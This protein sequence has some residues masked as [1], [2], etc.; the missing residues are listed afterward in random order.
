MKYVVT[1]GAGFIGSHLVKQLI[2]ENHHVAVIDTLI[3]GKLEN[4]IPYHSEVEFYN[5]DITDVKAL[6]PVLSKADGIFHQAALT[7]VQESF[8]KPQLYHTVNVEGTENIFMLAKKFKI[9][10]V[11]ASSSSVYG[12][13]QKIPITE[14]SIRRPV[15]PYGQT[16]LE[17]EY[18]AQKYSKEG[19]DVIGLR[20][21][22][23]YGVGQN[24]SYAGVITKFINRLRQ[25]K[26]PVIFGTGSQ[27]RDFVFVE[28]VAKANIA[29]MSCPR[30]GFY[31]VGTGIATSINELAK[32]L[33]ELSGLDL[34]PVYEDPLP[35]DVQA[36]QAD[37]TLAQKELCW[38]YQTTL[39]DGLGVFFR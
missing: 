27:V 13:P 11:Y 16:K 38:K 19:L 10:V 23:V 5:I 1:G 21:F 8:A 17:D 28:D 6:E 39:K 37:T 22:N 25:K 9:K 3:R 34:V 7:D 36:S 24:P 4:L 2:R 14:D 35:G 26:P 31:N 32:I 15:N 30:S 33:I 12:N 18:L 29:A 20:Y